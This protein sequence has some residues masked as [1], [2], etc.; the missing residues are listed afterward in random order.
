MLCNPHEFAEVLPKFIMCDLISSGK[1][2]AKSHICDAL[3]RSVNDYRQYWKQNTIIPHLE[4]ATQ[5]E[6]ACAHN[7]V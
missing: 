5:T 7:Q 6:C 2:S 1:L 3:K 4:R